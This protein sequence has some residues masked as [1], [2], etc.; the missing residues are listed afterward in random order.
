MNKILKKGKIV[1]ASVLAILMFVSSMPITVMAAETDASGSDINGLISSSNSGASYSL[2]NTLVNEPVGYRFSAV[3]TEGAKVTGSSVDVYHKGKYNDSRYCITKRWG[4]IKWKNE[5]TKNNYKINEDWLKYKMVSKCEKVFTDS[6]LGITLPDC[7]DKYSNIN[8]KSYLGHTDIIHNFVKDSD[9]LKEIIRKI[10]NDKNLTWD[11]FSK[12]KLLVVE[13]LYYTNITVKG[14]LKKLVTTPTEL[15]ACGQ[16]AMKNNNGYIKSEDKPQK[17]QFV[18]KYSNKL[19]PIAIYEDEHFQT[20]FR[21]IIPYISSTKVT[22]MSDAKDSDDKAYETC[23]NIITK[24]YGMGFIYNENDPPVYLKI[25]Y[26]L[27]PGIA[28]SLSNSSYKLNSSKYIKTKD[29]Y[30]EQCLSKGKKLANG[31]VNHSTFGVEYEYY[32]HLGKWRLCKADSEKYY[33][34]K[35]KSFNE[36]TKNLTITSILNL[37]IKEGETLKQN[38][39]ITVV[40]EAA[41]NKL[42]L[43]YKA[44]YKSS[45]DPYIKDW[46]ID[47]NYSI[48]KTADSDGYRYI[49]EPNGSSRT[50]VTQ[51]FYSDTE[52]DLVNASTFK[53][54]RENCSFAGWE[55]GS[56]ILNQTSNYSGN[57]I[58]QCAGKGA[59]A[60]RYS[61]ADIYV[62]ANAVWNEFSYV[63]Y[64]SNNKLNKEKTESALVGT[65]KILADINALNFKENQQ[66]QFLGWALSRTGDVKYL[67]KTNITMPATVGA[68]LHLYAKWSSEPTYSVYYNTNNSNA[69]INTNDKLIINNFVCD[70]NKNKICTKIKKSETFSYGVDYST[71]ED[72]INKEIKPTGWTLGGYE[73]NKTI[74][75]TDNKLKTDDIIN[76]CVKNNVTS[77][78]LY[79][80]WPKVK[81]QLILKYHADKSDIEKINNGVA[82]SIES[83]SQ[84][85]SY[86]INPNTIQVK[87]SIN[88]SYAWTIAKGKENQTIL[89]N[90]GIYNTDLFMKLADETIKET[91]GTGNVIYTYTVNLYGNWVNG[92]NVYYYGDEITS[93]KISDIIANKIGNNE[94]TLSSVVVDGVTIDS[95]NES[96]SL[97]DVCDKAGITDNKI[98]E[99]SSTVKIRYATYDASKNTN[100][101]TSK[102]VLIV[103][104]MPPTLIAKDRSFDIFDVVGLDNSVL[105]DTVY[106]Q[107]AEDGD[108][109]SNVK[110]EKIV[111]NKDEE[112]KDFEGNVVNKLSKLGV[113]KYKVYYSVNDS[114]GKVTKTFA[115]ITIEYSDVNYNTANKYYTRFISRNYYPMLHSETIANSVENNQ[116]YYI[117]KKVNGIL[118]YVDVLGNCT[119]YNVEACPEVTIKISEN[120]DF[121]KVF[122]VSDWLRK[123]EYI[124]ELTNILN[125]EKN[126]ENNWVNSQSIWMFTNDDIQVLKN[127]ILTYG[128]DND[129]C[130]NNRCYQ[131]YKKNNENLTGGIGYYVE[132]NVLYINSKDNTIIPNYSKENPA[133]W[134]EL[135]FYKVVFDDN[136]T[137][138][139][140]Y[141][142][143]NQNQI[144]EE[145][146]LPEDCSS[147]GSFAFANCTSAYGTLILNNKCKEI[148]ESAFENCNNISFLVLNNQKLTIGTKAFADCSNLRASLSFAESAIINDYAFYNCQNLSSVINEHDYDSIGEF[149]FAY[150]SNMNTL[151]CSNNFT[152]DE[153][154]M[155]AFAGC[156]NLDTINENNTITTDMVA[157]GLFYACSKLPSI[158][159]KAVPHETRVYDREKSKENWKNVFFPYLKEQSN[160]NTTI[161]NEMLNINELSFMNCDNLNKV[162]VFSN[163]NE[164]LGRCVDECSHDYYYK[165]I[166]YKY[167]IYK[168]GNY[169]LGD[170]TFYNCNSLKSFYSSANLIKTI[171]E[172]S[173]ENKQVENDKYK[174]SVGKY[175]FDTENFVSTTLKFYR[176]LYNNPIDYHSFNDG[177]CLKDEDY[178]YE[179]TVNEKN[180][181]DITRET[182]QLRAY[183]IDE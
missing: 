81:S 77:V 52:K 142:F 8:D 123:T 31:L 172:I 78:T 154:G 54:Q 106:S 48:N 152:F 136:I 55:I 36:D 133:P 98:K 164:F 62:T 49:Y 59:D 131:V 84:N 179:S 76:Y 132:N 4:K 117:A 162:E 101:T 19:Y 165:H 103:Y 119:K 35:Y 97:M 50:K 70:K 45:Y 46:D 91:D 1:I 143:Y 82:Y 73:A 13:P 23:K 93:I 16:H 26:R 90:N 14:E 138:I 159:I 15:A 37:N 83:G 125:N 177:H 32:H 56:T 51:N 64:H 145:I 126:N 18:A 58:G 25:R 173:D 171:C 141:A 144:K 121:Y 24:A 109:T 11:S 69:T 110:I 182:L 130:D 89:K 38:T 2:E 29:G 99:K 168:S 30:Y 47:H 95:V 163:V 180:N 71:I 5:Y 111:S 104:N 65:N 20:D 120:G 134:S 21:Y 151:T 7:I 158:K 72:G 170:A 174:N 3:I 124:S 157:K 92:K 150:C 116:I 181:K 178:V 147:I 113:G 60:L 166:P 102:N 86:T 129:F 67:N 57:Y 12:T 127:N 34:G 39:T 40:S 160:Y 79:A 146:I 122:P 43:R 44:P 149:A 139:G 176:N 17:F 87:E 155:Y 108:L 107:D 75:N 135:S 169:S 88:D 161:F 10:M 6:G 74:Y 68:Y 85:G 140:D 61:N 167:Y 27:D 183:R 153:V 41:K 53:L 94:F 156:R 96:K 42:I 22:D 9:A 114:Q 66:A 33:S 80:V 115:N 128:F 105:L 112:I 148:G 137:R 63:T 175:I 100:I 118:Y 28:S